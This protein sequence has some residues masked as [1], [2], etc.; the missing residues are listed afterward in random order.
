MTEAPAAVAYLLS[1]TGTAGRA[2]A[3]ASI[4][5]HVPA[6]I[7]LDSSGKQ[8]ISWSLCG[9]LSWG[10]ASKSIVGITRRVPLA[11][12]ASYTAVQK[13]SLVGSG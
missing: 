8:R 6:G 2:V 4:R 1:L 13:Q 9:Y 5:S 10:S 12:V 7:P 11:I 3:E